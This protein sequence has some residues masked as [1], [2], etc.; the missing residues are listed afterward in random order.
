MILIRIGKRIAR[1]IPQSRGIQ[2]I[3]FDLKSTKYSSKCFYFTVDHLTSENQIRC[4]YSGEELGIKKYQESRK[5]VEHAIANHLFFKQQLRK[6]LLNA[7]YSLTH[8]EYALKNLLHIMCN[9][10]T[11]MSILKDTLRT[12]IY[13]RK[14]FEGDKYRF[15]TIILRAF[16]FLNMPD[17]AI[18]V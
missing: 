1:T 3:P 9:A 2:I 18:E 7:D 11:D 17:E 6:Q 13:K 10:Q 14:D 12:L 4:L 16:H 5:V 15:D 8:L